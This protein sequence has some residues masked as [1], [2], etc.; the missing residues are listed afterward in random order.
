LPDEYAP[1]KV[2]ILL[3][4]HTGAPATP[5]VRAGDL[6]SRGQLIADIP[7]GALGA[8][9]HASVDGKVEQVTASAIEIRNGGK[10][11]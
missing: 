1:E 7:E 10:R 2:T 9:I 3:K 6:V 5:V 4:Q 11:S 8:R